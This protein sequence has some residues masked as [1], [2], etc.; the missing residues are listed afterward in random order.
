[1]SDNLTFFEQNLRRYQR[2]T[3]T[4]F[5]PP[6]LS[7]FATASGYFIPQYDYFLAFSFERFLMRALVDSNRGAYSFLYFVP[8][9]VAIALIGIFLY[10]T[11]MSAKGKFWALLSGSILYLADSVYCFVLLIPSSYAAMS[12]PNALLPIVIHL[13]FLLLYGF[14]IAKYVKLVRPSGKGS[15]DL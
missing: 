6:L 7:M 12:W 10:V 4:L 3:L 15:P 13:V 9:I 14:A 11:L 2:L 1:M 5:Y 8:L